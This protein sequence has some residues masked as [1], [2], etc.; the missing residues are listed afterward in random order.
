[1][2]TMNPTSNP[3]PG[4]TKKPKLAIFDAD[5]LLFYASW[6]L[7][8]QMTNIGKMAGKK[9]VDEIIT[10]ILNRTEADYFVGFY[11]VSSSET[12]RHA[13]ATVKP[14]KGGRKSEPWQEFFKPI[15]K[16]HYTDKWNFYGTRQL[17][18][19]DAV[20]IAHEIYKDDYEI[21]MVGED[22]DMK[23]NLPGFKQFNP[24]TN[25]MIINHE[26]DCRKFIYLQML[27]GDSSDHITGVQGVGDKAPIVKQIQE[28]E[29]P[30]QEELFTLVR[31][32]YIEVYGEDYLYHMIENYVL[33]KMMRKPSFDYPENVVLQ[34]VEKKKSILK[35]LNI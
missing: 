16:Q 1:M 5:G 17:E 34:K 21:I 22:K 32:K 27:H 11:G 19:D 31:D 13:W 23:S 8:T 18:A 24:R 33:L 4:K 20:I 15:I 3:T 35:S 26:V 28:L 7:R 6:S 25:Q 30:S 9:K 10:A 29:N 2:T 14:Y 12:F